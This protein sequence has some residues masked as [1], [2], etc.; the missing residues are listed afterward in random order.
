MHQL[1]CSIV[2][3]KNDISVLNK[4]IESVLQTNLDI[5]L[6]LIDNSPTD[7]LRK[8]ACAKT[9]D[10]VFNNKNFGFGN[11]HNIALQKAVESAPYHLVLNPD[12]EFENGLLE[13]TFA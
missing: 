10:Y 11:A 5:K 12:I 3:Y 8:I 9:I 1:T 2:L 6:Y 7:D 13:V 4:A